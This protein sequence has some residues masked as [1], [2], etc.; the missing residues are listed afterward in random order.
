[1]SGDRLRLGFIALNDAAAIIAADALGYFADEGLAVDLVRE[2]SWATMRDKLAVGALDGAHLLAP[3]A[4]ATTLG[5]PGGA[6][7]PLAAPMALN[8]NGP[9]VTLASRLTAAFGEG[10]DASGLARLVSRREAEGASPLTLAVVFPFSVHAYLLRDWL[11]RAGVDPDRDVRLTV[12]PPSRMTELLVGGVVEGFCVTEPWDTA[13]VVAGAGAIVIRGGD[14][15]PRTPD[16]VFAVTEAWADADPPRLRA[17]LR[18]LLRGAAWADAPENRDAL[19]QLLARPDRV[20]AS[21]EVIAA[22]LVDIIYDLDGASVPQPIHAAWMLTQ[23]MRWGH[24][25][26]ELDIARVAQRLYRPDLHALAAGDLGRTPVPT[27][28][29]LEGFSPLGSYRLQD[30]HDYAAR[31]ALSRLAK[32]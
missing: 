29:A 6:A 15:W 23:M 9:A 25:A 18:A 3:L 19:A 31:G 24:V 20:G 4:L 27:L 5:I 11:A 8:L 2:V 1:M 21:A 12:A 17:L 7:T 32:R 10:P 26:R 14:L 16:K 22:S 28:A 13:A 30:A